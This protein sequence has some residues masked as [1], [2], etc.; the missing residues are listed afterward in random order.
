MWKA[1]EQY[2][3]LREANLALLKTLT[4]DQWKHHGMHN[5]RGAETIEMI[6]RMFAGHDL[7]HFQ[8]IERI[9]SAKKK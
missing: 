8:Q 6:A 5:E 1:L 4:P 2:R 3:G 7:N 9:L